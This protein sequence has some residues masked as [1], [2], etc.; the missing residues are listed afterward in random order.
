MTEWTAAVIA[1][2]VSGP[3]TL[4]LEE[5]WIKN[6]TIATG[7]VDTYSTQTLIRLARSRQIDPSAFITDE[8]TRAEVPVEDADVV[9]GRQHVGGHQQLLVRHAGRDEVCGR[10]RKRHSYVFGLGAI[11]L[12]AEDPSSPAEALATCRPGSSGRR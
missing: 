5:L 12:V 4:H 8:V 11:D 6:V 2:L 1:L 3:A 10:V 7:L 9:A